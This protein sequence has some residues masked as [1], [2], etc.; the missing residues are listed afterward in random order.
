M[1]WCVYVGGKGDI[2][3]FNFYKLNLKFKQKDEMP[4]EWDMIVDQVDDVIADFLKIYGIDMDFLYTTNVGLL[5]V[6]S[7]NQRSILWD[8]S[9][10]AI[11]IEYLDFIF[12]MIKTKSSHLSVMTCLY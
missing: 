12:W 4:K 3:N 10:W 6:A 5:N 9:Y 2:M 7:N 1:I 11:Y 8:L